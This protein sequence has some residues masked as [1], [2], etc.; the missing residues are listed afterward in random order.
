M[1]HR[2]FSRRSAI[3]TLR[4][5]YGCY[6]RLRE[7]ERARKLLQRRRKR[8]ANGTK[9]QTWRDRAQQC[10]LVVAAQHAVCLRC[11]KWSG[12]ISGAWRVRELRLLSIN[13]AQE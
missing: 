3:G 13:G 10:G 1:R 2:N 4:C 5:R 12:N 7:R 6:R 8:G 11:S 9:H